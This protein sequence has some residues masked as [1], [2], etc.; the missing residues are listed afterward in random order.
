M[1]KHVFTLFVIMGSLLMCAAA[2]LIKT[3]L[4]SPRTVRT[5]TQ[6]QLGAAWQSPVEGADISEPFGAVFDEA[7]G[8]WTLLERA[9]LRAETGAFVR[10]MQAG[11]VLESRE[12]DGAW[13]VVLAHED[14]AL[15]SYG[16]LRAGL[17]AG[18]RVMQGELIGQL[19]GDALSLGWQAEGR[20][21]DPMEILPGAP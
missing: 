10:A 3:G 13:T 16:G 8:Q 12:E 4:L 19:A 20:W 21:R 9:L 7:L 14:G 5:E 2:W 6:A 11:R 17:T 15:T 18:R 1:K